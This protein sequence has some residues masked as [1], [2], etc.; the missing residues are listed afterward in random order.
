M[1]EKLKREKVP[2]SLSAYIHGGRPIIPLKGASILCSQ[3]QRAWQNYL[4]C[5]LPTTQRSYKP[6]RAFSK[7][8]HKTTAESSRRR[9]RSR[10]DIRGRDR[11]WYT[12]SRF[13]FRSGRRVS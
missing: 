9:R 1:D 5:Y 6:K 4:S 8:G 12:S 11:A 2:F 13:T 10:I 7:A 3:V